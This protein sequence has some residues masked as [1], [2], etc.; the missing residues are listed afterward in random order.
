MFSSISINQTTS[1]SPQETLFFSLKL[2]KIP[3][4]QYYHH[5]NAHI[6]R[7][8]QHMTFTHLQQ[9]QHVQTPTWL[10]YMRGYYIRD[11]HHGNKPLLIPSYKLYLLVS[12]RFT[13]LFIF[14]SAFGFFLFSTAIYTPHMQ[15][16]LK[17]ILVIS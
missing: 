12:V 14:V 15:L 10:S 9:L 11:T 16:R 5:L 7:D 8:G 3:K 1:L 6:W 4:Q 13:K 2:D 17:V